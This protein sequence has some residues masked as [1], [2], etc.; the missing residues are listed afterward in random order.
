MGVMEMASGAANVGAG[1]AESASETAYRWVRTRILDGELPGGTMLSEGPVAE[2]LGMS[3]T[4]VREAFLRLQVE[5]WMRLYPKRGAL[6]IEPMPGEREDIVAARVLFEADAVRRL[7]GDA[8]VREQ[9]TARLRE[10]LIEQREAAAA[11]DLH[12]F[13]DADAEF[14]AAIV[15]AGGNRLLS[16]F[17]ATLRDR[18]RRMTAMSMRNRAERIEQVLVDHDGL[19]DVIDSG[20]AA[21]FETALQAHLRHAHR[22]LLA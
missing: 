8:P 15:A 19:I 4:P 7:V 12:R 3:R 20:D 13:A 2:S 21:A 10:I 16:G 17:F 9:L 5:G 14:H 22:E 11:A 6:V 18:Q 1:P